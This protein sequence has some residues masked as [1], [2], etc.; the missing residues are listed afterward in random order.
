MQK[1]TSSDNVLSNIYKQRR[2]ILLIQ[3]NNAQPFKEKQQ[4][5]GN[6]SSYMI[7]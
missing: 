7:S 3:T 4:M 5:V 1:N 2:G 6:K